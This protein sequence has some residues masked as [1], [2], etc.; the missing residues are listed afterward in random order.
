VCLPQLGER[1]RRDARRTVDHIVVREHERSVARAP[2]VDLDHL[3]AVR[4][5]ALDAIERVRRGKRSA[6]AVGDAHY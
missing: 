5:R 6:A 4:Q 3:Q 2:H 1:C